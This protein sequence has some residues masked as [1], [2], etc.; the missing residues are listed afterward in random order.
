M[1]FFNDTPLATSLARVQLMYEDI[2]QAIVVVKGTYVVTPSGEVQLADEQLPVLLEDTETPDGVFDTEVVP[3]KAGCDVALL[4]HA[5][6]PDPNRPVA[7]MLVKL[8][9]DKFERDLHV[10][11]DRTWVKSGGAYRPSRPAPFTS[12]PLTYERAYGGIAE[13]EDGIAGP[14]FDNPFGRGYLVHEDAVAGAP[15]PN[16]EEPD[17]L[18]TAWDQRPPVAGVAPLSRQSALRGLR[19]VH[20]DLEAQTTRID[21]AMFTFAHP[22]MTLPAYPGGKTVRIA[23]V[24]PGVAPWSFVL[25]KFEHSLRVELGDAAYQLPIVADTLYLLPD[26][27]M[28]VVLGRRTVL[29]QFRPERLRS[30][31]VLA[32]P[33]EAELARPTTIRALRERPSPDLPIRPEPSQLG[34]M[35][36]MEALLA[37]HPMAEILETL[38]L[39]PS[40]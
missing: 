23:G 28:F 15:L 18:L 11:G 2:L 32:T 21:P 36:P 34:L 20:V 35:L 40:A 1:Q 16:I 19:G 12:M 14:H 17:D 5:R 31:R 39:C 7:S 8:A 26:A 30:L 24:R 22:R 10:S 3:I 6:S 25:P 38:P 9:I 27:R 37:A 4:G 29:Y 13:I 33:S